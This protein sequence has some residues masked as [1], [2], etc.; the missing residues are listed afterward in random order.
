MAYYKERKEFFGGLLILYQ[1]DLEKAVPK[2]KTHRLPNWYM[3]AKIDGNWIERSTKHTVYEDAY[4]YASK[5]FHRLQHKAMLGHPLEDYTFE[6]HWDDWYE[7]MSRSGDWNAERKRWHKTYGKTFKKYFCADGASLLLNEVTPKV[8]KGYWDWRRSDKGKSKATSR[9]LAP[10]SLQM[11]QS[12]LNQIFFD[13]SE[14]GRLQQVIKFR[15]PRFNDG[16]RRRPAFDWSEYKSL[17]EQLRH[18]RD[19]THKFKNDDANL[20]DWHRLQRKQLYYF[21]LFMANSG[22]RVGEAREMRWEDVKFDQVSPSLDELIAEVEVR[23]ST[24]T[25]KNRPVQTQ[26]AANKA[27]LEWQKV[28]PFKAPNDFVWFGQQKQKGDKQVQFTDLNKSFQILLA[29]ATY[30]DREK[31]LL[32][33]KENEKRS[34]YSLR[35]YYAT[36]R[37]EKDEVSVYDLSLNMGCKVAQIEKH[38]SHTDA[39]RKRAAITKSKSLEKARQEEKKVERVTL[40]DAAADAFAAFQRGEIDESEFI[41]LVRADKAPQSS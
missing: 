28:T 31:G 16:V 5:E 3:K 21:V 27:L 20:N 39:K 34:L 33:S 2:S 18:Y 26:P 11:E 22:L 13:A 41:K 25:R 1:R 6:D 9:A 19:C 32:F 4:M 29:R 17:I 38:Y 37:L 14:E 15:A 30:K 35:H 23:K 8:V 36:Q 10:K 12:A 7:R 24:K 40:S